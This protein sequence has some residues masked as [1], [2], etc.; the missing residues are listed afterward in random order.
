MAS[1]H[2]RGEVV[3]AGGGVVGLASAWR[4]AQA[5][6]AVTVYDPD[7]GRGASWAAAGMLAPATEATFGEEALLALNLAAAER[8]DGFAEELAEASGMDPGLRRSGAM[9]VARDADDARVLDRLADYHARLGLPSRRLRSREARELEPGLS[10]RTR[11]AM[12]CEGDHQV[13]NRAL[14]SALQRAAAGAGV[15]FARAAVTGVA[16]EHGRVTGARLSTGHTHGCD[17]VVVAAGWRSGEIAGVGQAVPVR[18]VK[19]QLLHLRE[20]D[21]HT[22]LATRVVRGLTVYVV[23]RGDGRVVI[24]ATV[25]ERDHDPVTTAGGVL[26]LLRDAW[27]LLPEVAELELVETAAGF[28]PTTPDNGPVIG[29]A[30]VDGA[31]F[32]FGHHRH[33]ILLTPITA[34]AVAQLVDGEQPPVET[35]AFTPQRFVTVA[36]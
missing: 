28:R 18:P 20:R 6:R 36:A 19:G 13:D 21:P 30:P 4:L 1:H 23:P 29:H 12:L 9:V 22:P 25:E 34:E 35:Q 24:G 17:H 27:E 14:V 33:G 8:W 2:E 3:I 15:R 11:G 26:Q 32:A 10:P 5:G 16:S 7:I 31:V